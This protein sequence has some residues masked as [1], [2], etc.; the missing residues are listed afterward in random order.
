MADKL[1][2]R[3]V[4]GVGASAGGL[5][6]LKAFFSHADQT[7][8][9]LAYVV[10]QH[11]APD[12]ESMLP[13]ILANR[14]RLRVQQARD[15]QTIESGTIYICPPGR[16]ISVQEGQLHLASPE[17]DAHVRHSIDTLFRSLAG[18]FGEDAVGV[19]LSGTGDDGSAGL[20]AITDAGG[21]SAAQ[22]PDTCEH[23]AMSRNAIQSGAV[24][25]VGAPESLLADI[26]K[27][28][29]EPRT[30]G[31]SELTEEEMRS[32]LEIVRDRTG[33]NFG[34]YKPGTLSRRI[35]RRMS[36]MR[37]DTI[38]EYLQRLTDNEEEIH[39]LAH[40]LLIGVTAFFRDSDTVQHIRMSLLPRLVEEAADSGT[41]RVWVAGCATGEEAYTLT[42]LLMEEIT[43]QGVP[44][45]LQV[46]ASDIDEQAL[47]VA[48]GAEYPASIASD[49]PLELLRKYFRETSTGTYEVGKAL[50]E[51]VV[52]ANQNLL[53][54]PPF[55]RIDLV[56][57]RNV[58][59]YLK[60]HVQE[61]ILTIFHFAL[62]PGGY[63]LLGASESI[64]RQSDKFEPVSRS[65]RIFQRVG[66]R[67]GELPKFPLQT[68]PQ[69]SQG[70]AAPSQPGA[71]SHKTLADAVHKFINDQ[72]AP[73]CVVVDEHHQVVYITRHAHAFLKLP[74]GEPT[75]DLCAMLDTV[76]GTR[77][78]GML[79]RV[80][81]T[82]E[83]EAPRQ[84]TLLAPAGRKN[85]SL[86]VHLRVL[87]FTCE[88][89]GGDLAI[90]VFERLRAP[91]AQPSEAAGDA[92]AYS[93]L[94]TEL[95][96]TKQDLQSTIEELEAANE[97]LKTSNEEAL[98]VNEELQSTNEELETSKE[99]LQSLNEELST[100]NA[101]LR[102]K[103]HEVE[104]VT[105]DI[106]NLLA[107]TDMGV[108]FLDSDLRIM[109]FTP[110]ITELFRIE[111]SDIGRSI[112]DIVRR[113]KYKKF[114]ND[115]RDVINKLVRSSTH[116][117]GENGKTYRQSIVPYRTQDSRIQG[118]VI[119]YAD[120]T[121][122]TSTIKRLER[123]ERQQTSL[124]E[125]GRYALAA[126]SLD[127]VFERA[128]RLALQSMGADYTKV[129]AYDAASDSFLLR[130]GMGWKKDVV[131]NAYVPNDT[132]S[133]AGYTFASHEPVIVTN[134]QSEKRFSGPDLL[135]NHGIVSGIS[136]VIEAQGQRWGVLG[137]HSRQE[138]KFT[139][140]DLAFMQ[141][142]ASILGQ[143]IQ[144]HQV[145]SQ[146]RT[147]AARLEFSMN[148]AA[149]GVWEYHAA[150]GEI[151]WSDQQK[152]LFG[153]PPSA[154]LNIDEAWA[155]FHEDDVDTVRD[156]VQRC[157]SDQLEYKGDF[158]VILPSGET[159]WLH[160][161]GAS[162]VGPDG[163]PIMY[164][165][166]IDITGRKRVEEQLKAS[167]SDLSERVTQSQK[168]A[169]QRLVEIRRMTHEMVVAE[170]DE[171]RRLASE[172]HDNLGQAIN[173][174]HMR[175]SSLTD[176]DNG[177]EIEHIC[178]ILKKASEMT[179]SITAQLS[180]QILDELGLPPALEWLAEEIQ[181]LYDVR[182]GVE[183]MH[184]P[185]GLTHAVEL[186]CF[187]AVRELLINV[188]K[189]A[190]VKEAS[191]RL[192]RAK[193]RFYIRVFDA[194]QGFNLEEIQRDLSGGYGLLSIKERFE[195]IQGD[196]D[197]RTSPGKG[198][199]VILSV[200]DPTETAPEK[201]D[202]DII[203]FQ[204]D[205]AV[206]EKLP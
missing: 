32:I 181:R 182:V 43:R 21:L 130:S 3:A 6:A 195:H 177:Q 107:S 170:S 54:D 200:P 101:Q 159:R 89:H 65:H 126:T 202:Q 151:F 26:A 9:D 10:V 84:I 47:A 94:E 190:K 55:S 23:D 17:G 30:L 106:S 153:L 108:L 161:A 148:A 147:N 162:I 149:I 61:S 75:R 31:R 91:A 134:L 183:R 205:D 163:E 8:P 57:C 2:L 67:K 135:L 69:A 85:E 15:R 48:R 133:Q 179:R 178:S 175:L 114:E 71:V 146:L 113:Y 24:H 203:T 123:S 192:T 5:D 154:E 53:S 156:Q 60:P 56:T 145:L 158:R 37:S 142:L 98:S 38:S 128:C 112:G 127:E 193:E 63:L 19:V 103:L 144:S 117:V 68:T 191:L 150:T 189:H 78:R 197:I 206:S 77:L 46:F 28:L 174:A 105:D 13:D 132:D 74:E 131:G 22:D 143:A 39:E 16:F 111:P 125:L 58:L 80:F 140:K 136:C 115:A 40:D 171:R 97:E 201:K 4:I 79:G 160:G 87:P 25:L 93:R 18:A 167:E 11:L 180:P 165:I 109:R 92:S 42:I 86:D 59:I 73:A 95:S 102:D 12:Y 83:A 186:I 124:A 138:R 33:K 45:D 168:I 157:I 164:G 1:P 141:T 41:L 7:T 172:L 88:E 96:S 118:V 81:R 76:A 188:A 116:I 64:G 139:S 121:E 27:A 70:I 204:K 173:L 29:D 155:A 184:D 166:N 90:V 49:I 120:I 36:L 129:L 100:V 169:E 34:Y 194:G 82:R 110:E 137:V 119:T 196:V 72:F 185:V 35:L 66:R 52:F 62:R 122:L 199:T 51:R 198:C 104:S 99:E 14:T 50:R 176:S 187:R 44:I 152:R 20:G